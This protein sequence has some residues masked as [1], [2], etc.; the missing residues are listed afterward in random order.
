[1]ASQAL[2]LI[3]TANT[4]QATT[5]LQ[6]LNGAINNVSSTTTAAVPATQQLASAV[7]R[8]GS[9]CGLLKLGIYQL[10]GT[11]IIDFLR[12]KTTAII[13]AGLA[14]EKYNSQMKAATGST[15][16]AALELQFIRGEAARLGVDMTAMTASYGKFLGAAKNTS[17]EGSQTRKIF[18]GISEGLE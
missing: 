14:L 9:A 4:S 7:E 18:I 5:N 1:M 13:Q 11:S 3:V 15:T 16:M 6:S 10:I 8:M 17:V 12:D 2:S